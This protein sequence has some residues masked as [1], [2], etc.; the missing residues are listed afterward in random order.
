MGSGISTKYEKTEGLMAIEKAK[1]QNNKLADVKNS[2]P[3][4]KEAFVDSKKFVEYS[5]DTN[6]PIGKHKALIYKETLGYDSSNYETLIRQIEN[7]VQADESIP[8]KIEITKW[9][10]RF[11]YNVPV[12]GLNGLERLVLTVFQIDSDSC[13]PRLITNYVLPQE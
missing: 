10:P 5:L 7:Y 8:N 3:C 12:K 2:M 11:Q 9:G 13:I 4:Y 6:H 1:G